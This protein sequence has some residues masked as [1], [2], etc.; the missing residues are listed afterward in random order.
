MTVIL[1]DSAHQR[2]L[3]TQ[4]MCDRISELPEQF[5]D[6]WPAMRDFRLPETYRNCSNVVICGMGGSAIGGDLVRTVVMDSCSKPIAVSREYELPAFV[7]ADSLV[8]ISSYS[9]NTEES[10]GA[11]EQ[12]KGRGAK[13]VA[14]S[15]GGSLLQRCQND[16]VACATFDYKSQPR[17]A[18]GHSL[19]PLLAI[20][21]SAG[22]IPSPEADVL[23]AVAVMRALRTQLGSDAPASGNLAKQ[24]AQRLPG[25]LPLIYGM[26]HGAEAARRWKGQFNENAKTTAFYDLLP[27]LNHNS[28]VGYQL[29]EDLAERIFVIVLQ[30]QSIHPGLKA[31]SEVTVGMLAERGIPCDV[32]HSQGVS[33]LAQAMSLV[34]VGDWTSYYLA[35]LYNV[36]PT[37]IVAIDRLKAI[38]AS[39]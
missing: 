7:D 6:S 32:I 20:L 9:G 16:G 4:R 17:A 38:L 30:P 13:V 22:L 35:L 28:V 27:E 5:N 10:L 25:R 14:V 37:P 29:P 21:H 23:E 12:A 19:V 26:A 36:D 34:Y 2:G 1:D 24:L 39:R 31:R 8:I 18:L 15:T 3:D 11:Y 33:R